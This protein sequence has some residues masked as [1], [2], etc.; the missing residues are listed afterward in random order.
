MTDLTTLRRTL[1]L[2]QAEIATL[3]GKHPNTIARYE[4]GDLQTP[5]AIIELLRLKA[6]H[7]PSV[8][9]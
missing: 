7:P 1:G 3:T 2:T 8:E 5:K 4:R 9:K 6:Q